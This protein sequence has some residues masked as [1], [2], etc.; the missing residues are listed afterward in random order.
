M[1][2]LGSIINGLLQIRGKVAVVCMTRLYTSCCRLI[3]VV[4]QNFLA[5]LLQ[6][7]L[8][9][10]VVVAIDSVLLHLR[11]NFGGSKDLL[12]F[13]LLLI[14]PVH[15]LYGRQVLIRRRAFQVTVKGIRSQLLTGQSAF[16]CRLT[17]LKR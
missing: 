14:R 8:D 17:L 6:A 7:L 1:F 2:L 12:L 10:L 9:R 15:L 16:S 11:L 4:L 5:V 13:G 3:R